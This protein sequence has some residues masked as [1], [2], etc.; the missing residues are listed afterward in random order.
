MLWGNRH[1]ILLPLQLLQR[2]LAELDRFLARDRVLPSPGS[3]VACTCLRSLTRLA[4]ARKR[5]PDNTHR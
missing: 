1:L 3:V 4:L 5:S 2:V